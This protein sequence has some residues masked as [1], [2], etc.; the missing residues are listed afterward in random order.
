[1]LPADL[2]TPKMAARLIGAHVSLIYRAIQDGRLRAYRR[3]GSR[4]LVSRADVVGLVVEVRA[5]ARRR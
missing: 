5:A 2:T 4:Y 1:M 3:A